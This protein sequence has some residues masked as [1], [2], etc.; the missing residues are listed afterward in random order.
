MEFNA[1]SNLHRK[2]WEWLRNPGNWFSNLW[3]VWHRRYDT[4]ILLSSSATRSAKEKW[5]VNGYL[6][7]TSIP[8][9]YR[10][11]PAISLQALQSNEQG[12]LY[13]TYGKRYP[14]K[15]DRSRIVGICVLCK[16][17]TNGRAES[18]QV[19]FWGKLWYHVPSRAGGQDSAHEF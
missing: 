18:I 3:G 4:W 13:S 2:L 10:R 8:N 19:K 11:L 17:Y 6:I 7:E 1:N 14:L 5:I 15:S 16:P 12:D 9:L